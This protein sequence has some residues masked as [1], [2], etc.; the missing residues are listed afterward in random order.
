M[1]N[2]SGTIWKLVEVH[3]TGE[4]GRE[5]EAPI[6]CPLGITMFGDERVLAA[7]T[8]TRP[9]LSP[10]APTRPFFS[11][12]GT[13]QWDGTTLSTVAD[14]ASKPDMVTEHVRDMHFDGPTRLVVTPKTSL[15]GR[16]AGLTFVWER[17]E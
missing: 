10:G 14:A 11:Y 12:T 17:V 16:T 4:D 1:Q 8:D 2:L 6:L 9:T 5:V 15:L 7:V 13:Y 3:A